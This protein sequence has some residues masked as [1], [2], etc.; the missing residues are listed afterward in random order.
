MKKKE[1][2]KIRSLFDCQK[3]KRKEAGDTRVGRKS[4]EER[5]EGPSGCD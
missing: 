4:R 2:Y 5:R 3:K 1:E